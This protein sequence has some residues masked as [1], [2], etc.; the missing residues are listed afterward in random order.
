M[1]VYDQI[2]KELKWLEENRGGNLNIL[3]ISRVVSSLSLLSMTVGEDV[4]SA[5]ALQNEME[6]A[7]DEL[8]AKRFVELKDTHSAAACK[9]IIEAELAQ[10]KKNWTAAKNGYNKLKIYLDRLDRILESNRQLV[11]TAKLDAKNI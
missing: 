9:P 8:Y 11:S 4:S 6:D 5:Y 7:Y 10:D 2:Q 1:N 3:G